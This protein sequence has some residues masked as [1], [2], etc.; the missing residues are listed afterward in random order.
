MKTILIIL[1]SLCL[2][3]LNAACVN[4]DCKNGIGVYKFENGS[5]FKGQFKLG[6]RDGKGILKLKSG[7][8]IKGYWKNNILCGKVME[9]YKNG[10]KLICYYENGKRHGKGRKF[11]QNG[12]PILNLSFDQGKLISKSTV[13]QNKSEAEAPRS[14]EEEVGDSGNTETAIEEVAPPPVELYPGDM[15]AFY[16]SYS[17]NTGDGSFFGNLMG[18]YL[19]A[20]FSVKFYGVVEQKLGDRYK[21]IITDGVIDD[22]SWA[23]ANYYTYRPYAAEEM[24]RVIGNTVFKTSPEVKLVDQ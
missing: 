10:T 12:N 24:N 21:I 8:K 4:G 23:S 18:A 6:K 11:D 1:F 3:Q 9:E 5:L 7:T 19:T 17:Y 13:D 15:V 20:D 22:P 16:D 2:T 14:D